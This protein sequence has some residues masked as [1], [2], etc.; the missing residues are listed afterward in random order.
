MRS[1]WLC[2]GDARGGYVYA[3]FARLCFVHH[4]TFCDN[5]LV[6]WLDESPFDDKRSSRDHLR[7]T[8][9][10]I[11]GE[12]YHN[13][14]HQFPM[15]YR[16]VVPVQPYKVV[17]LGLPEARIGVASEGTADVIPRLAVG[18]QRPPVI[19]WDSYIE[20]TAKRPLILISGFIHDVASLIDEH[21][22]GARFIKTTTRTPRTMSLLA[23]KRV[24]VLHGSTPLAVDNKVIPS[25]QRLKIARYAELSSPNASSTPHSDYEGKE[26]MLG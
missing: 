10:F 23:M 1:L 22:G 5:W 3:R 11:I 13:F 19:S 8:A 12:G 4:S 16:N 24:G 25:S 9:L 17:H 15:D 18:Q 6:H 14:H 26:G 2:W 7:V 20:Q 21:P